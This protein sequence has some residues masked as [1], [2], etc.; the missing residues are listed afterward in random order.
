MQKRKQRK[1]HCGEIAMARARQ[2][3]RQKKNPML[4]G[5]IFITALLSLRTPAMLPVTPHRTNADTDW[6]I[7]DYER[8]YSTLPKPCRERYSEQ[9]TLK[10]L[11]RD[12]RRPAACDDATQFLLA[13]IDDVDLRGWIIEQIREDRI[14]RLA[15]HVR[16]GL[17]DAAVL[18]SWQAELDAENTA[19]DKA[20]NDTATQAELMRIVTEL[21][22]TNPPAKSRTRV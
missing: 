2:A 10:R 6:P 3:R 19:I 8:G 21:T 1:K 12:L 18:K 4:I 17:N 9:P 7:S 22:A 20:V 15:I 14:N 11:M 5:W 13:R 16:P